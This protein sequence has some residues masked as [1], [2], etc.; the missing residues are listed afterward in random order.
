MPDRSLL[1][2]VLLLL[3][4]AQTGRAA[5]YHGSSGQLEASADFVV[6]GD[7][8]IVTLTNTSSY[9]VTMPSEVLTAVFFDSATMLSLTRHS[10]VLGLDSNIVRVP[11]GVIGPPTGT[12]AG[13]SVGGEW[14]YRDDLPHDAFTQ[15][16][17]GISSVGLADGADFGD[18]AWRFPGGNLEGPGTPD[19]LQYGIVPLADDLTT[20]NGGLR[21]RNLI[22]HQVV[23]T[24]SGLPDGFSVDAIEN[25]YFKYGTS[26]DEG[27][28][29]A[30]GIT[31]DDDLSGPAP[32]PT[33][34]ALSAGAAAL[35]AMML[36]R[37]WGG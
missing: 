31:V 22:Q 3:L 9:D 11:E 23:F 37:R 27:G 21:D 18:V 32:V 1:L 8:L 33:P 12:E 4:T 10:A 19:G 36:R 24:L 7:D 34:E 29:A 30:T 2:T 17:Y 35:A 26:Y 28:Y 25:V 16:Q 13:D 20:G 14:A 6:A 15:S 5:T